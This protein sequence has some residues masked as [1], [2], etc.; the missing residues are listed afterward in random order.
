MRA[1]HSGLYRQRPHTRQSPEGSCDII[2]I[3]ACIAPLHRESVNP[4]NKIPMKVV[5][6]KKG[7]STDD[8]TFK[9]SESLKIHLKLD[10]QGENF[11]LSPAHQI[12]NN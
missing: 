8:L 3:I 5:L 6:H 4:L 10:I 7:K 12:N 11:L 1:I 2:I 9:N